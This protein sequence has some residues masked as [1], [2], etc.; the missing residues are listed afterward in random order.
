[1]IEAVEQVVVKDL[2]YTYPGCFEPA[3]RG[4]NLRVSRGSFTL[5]TGPSGCGKTTL[6]RCLNGLIPH[7]YG[8]VLKGRVLVEGLEV[9]S[10]PTHEVAKLVGM[11]FQEPEDQLIQLTV[12]REVAFGPENLGLPRSEVRDR[13]EEALTA[14][15]LSHLRD[16]APF[17]LSGGEQQ[18][19][20]LAAALALKPS[21][22]VLDEPTSNL[23]PASAADF[24]KLLVDLNRE[25]LTVILVEHRLDLAAR[26][27][28]QAVLMSE[29][30]IVLEGPPREVLAS[31]EAWRLGVAVPKT[32]ELYRELS[33]RGLR[34]PHPPLDPEELARGLVELLERRPR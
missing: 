33:A 34:L 13:V 27:S 1:V 15:R 19:V 23:D 29:G 8:G 32:V 4:V 24:I 21:V 10:K 26:Y 16:K 9:A 12:E 25:G 7:F 20:A 6:C 17:E 31:D 2:W 3:L 22:L 5:I 14:L 30:R 18:K 11:V 28:D